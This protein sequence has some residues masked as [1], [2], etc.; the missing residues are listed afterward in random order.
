[1]IL[2][3]QLR[4]SDDGK[5][6]YINLHVNQADY[7]KNIYLDKLVIMS[8]DKVSE[9]DPSLPTENYL[10]TYTFEENQKEAALVLTANDFI[11]TWETE[12]QKMVFTDEDMQNTLFFV[13]VQCKGTVGACTPCRL[14]E[15]TTVGVTFDEKQLYQRIMGYTKSLADTCSIPVG[16]TDFILLWNAF[17]A[18]IETDHYISA[19]G[20]WNM[21][22]GINNS[23]QV[24]YQY[25]G[26]GCHG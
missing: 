12:V 18:A 22:F 25:K 8:G 4:L 19:I 11:K 16:F 2:F 24:S 17:K 3:D 14:D 6:I 23:G 20:Y 13:Y 1:M 7:F 26:C 9:T 15:L 10:Y 5:K 21:L